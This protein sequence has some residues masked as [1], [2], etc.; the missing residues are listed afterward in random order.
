[1]SRAELTAMKRF[2]WVRCSVAGMSLA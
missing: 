1:M 2:R